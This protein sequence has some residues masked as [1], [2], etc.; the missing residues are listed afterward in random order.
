[1]PVAWSE[2]LDAFEFLSSSA[3]FGNSAWV[4][5]E[6]GA[7]HMHSDWDEE[8]WPLPE[9]IDD[10][11]KYVALPSPRDLELGRPLVMRF[12]AERLDEHYDEI[13]AIFFPQ[14]RLSALQGLSRPH[15]RPRELVRLRRDRVRAALIVA[16]L[17][18]RRRFVER[19]HDRADLAANEPVFRQIAQRRDRVEEARDF[20]AFRGRSSHHKTQQVTKRGFS[21]AVRR[22]S[23]ASR[24]HRLSA[25][26]KSSL[27]RRGD[28]VAK[29]RF[30]TLCRNSETSPAARLLA[31]DMRSIRRP[32]PEHLRR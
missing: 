1:M 17:D 30:F 26:S 21:G 15:R 19:F 5:R 9:D 27:P 2:I 10:A 11:E 3:E 25:R 8:L 7:V 16:E 14:G 4:C 6:T 13:A 20:I 18:K 32:H 28:P 12:A 24:E 23:N 31:T 22:T 29:R